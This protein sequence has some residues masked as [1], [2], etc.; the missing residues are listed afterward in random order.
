MILAHLLIEKTTMGDVMVGTS[1]FLNSKL[2]M[3]NVKKEKAIFKRPDT[4]VKKL[5]IKTKKTITL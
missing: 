2:S 5:H 3:V 1:T 4:E